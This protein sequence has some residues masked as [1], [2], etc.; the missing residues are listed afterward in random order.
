MITVNVYWWMCIN[1]CRV[2][3]IPYKEIY[4]L[5][6]GYSDKDI[7]IRQINFTGVGLEGIFL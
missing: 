3:E 7:L 2:E 6:E 4:Y 1:V 5:K